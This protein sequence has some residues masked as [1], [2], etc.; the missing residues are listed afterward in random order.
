MTV[1]KYVL[2]LEKRFSGP[3]T[4]GDHSTFVELSMV[5]CGVKAEKKRE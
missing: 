1:K 3:G 4:G 2:C 5:K